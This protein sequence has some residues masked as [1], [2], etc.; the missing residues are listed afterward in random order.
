MAATKNLPPAARP[1][2]KATQKVSN[3]DLARLRGFFDADLLPL[4]SNS[5]GGPADKSGLARDLRP[6]RLL[7]AVAIDHP[8]RVQSAHQHV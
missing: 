1:W 6:M 3:Q 7:T 2:A 5:P 4:P 8:T